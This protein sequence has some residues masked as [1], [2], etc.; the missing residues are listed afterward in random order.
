VNG[1]FSRFQPRQVSAP[2]GRVRSWKFLS[3]QA[4]DDR[5]R[6]RDDLDEDR[7]EVRRAFVLQERRAPVVAVESL[8]GDVVPR[9]PLLELEWA[10]PGRM[11]VIVRAEFGAGGG[12]G[13]AE[14]R[15]PEEVARHRAI[16]LRGGDDERVVV[17][18]V[19][20]R[21]GR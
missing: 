4:G 11:A 14:E 15:V 16:G 6:L 18:C 2:D 12:A 5:V 1:H 8:Q 17:R 10:C 19:E 7:I 21:F 20:G 3:L 13:D 9:D